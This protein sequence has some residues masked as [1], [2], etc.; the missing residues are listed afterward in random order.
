MID[1]IQIKD[2]SERGREIGVVND[3][4]CSLSVTN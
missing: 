3:E 2:G 4:T 1:S